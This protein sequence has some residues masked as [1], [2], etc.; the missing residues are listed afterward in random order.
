MFGDERASEKEISMFF[1][2]APEAGFSGFRDN[3]AGD[4]CAYVQSPLLRLL[5]TSSLLDLK[6]NIQF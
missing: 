6:P 5:Q 4:A 1:G 2:A 3:E